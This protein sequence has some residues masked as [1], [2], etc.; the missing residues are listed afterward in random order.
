MDNG[1]SNVRPYEARFTS[2]FVTNGHPR[3]VLEMYQM[4]PNKSDSF[5]PVPDVQQRRNIDAKKTSQRHMYLQMD[6]FLASTGRLF[7]GSM[8]FIFPIR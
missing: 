5:G 8:D 2:C 6:A 3:D 4:I 7:K 1:T